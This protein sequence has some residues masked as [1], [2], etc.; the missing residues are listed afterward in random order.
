MMI[1]LSETTRVQAP[2]KDIRSPKD[3]IQL[4]NKVTSIHTLGP[5]GTNCERAAQHWLTAQGKP[6]EIY[7]YPTLEAAALSMKGQAGAALLGCVVYPELHTLVFSNLDWL[8]LADSFIIPTHNMVLA[9]KET[10]Q[11]LSLVSSHPAPVG[12]IPASIKQRRLVNS[13]VQAAIDCSQDLSDCC[14]TTSVAA[15][16][17]NLKVVQDFGPVLMGFTIHTQLAN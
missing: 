14:I 2:L 10:T 7:L 4:H 17:Y 12:L 13:N 5:T 16:K 8:T 11:S 9:A 6:V 3:L 15:Q 1:T